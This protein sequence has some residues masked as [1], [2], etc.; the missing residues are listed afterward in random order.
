MVERRSSSLQRGSALTARK[1]LASTSPKAEFCSSWET[2]S[3]VGTLLRLT[4]ITSSNNFGGTILLLLRLMKRSI[5]I[6]NAS[7][8]QAIRGQIVQPAACMME[9]KCLLRSDDGLL[10]YGPPATVPVM[11]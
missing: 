6:A 1:P 8:E 2:T 11:G 9:N 5:T 10:D 3:G 4:L 7:I